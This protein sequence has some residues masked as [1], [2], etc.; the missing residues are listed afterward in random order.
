MIKPVIGSSRPFLLLLVSS[1]ALAAC[2]DDEAMDYCKNHYRFHPEHKA[3][4][5]TLKVELA[6]DGRLHSE[7]M[8]PFALFGENGAAARDR[9]ETIGRKLQAEGQFYSLQSERPCGPFTVTQDFTGGALRLASTAQCGADNKVEQVDVA[10]FDTLP[11]LDEIEVLVTTP[12]TAKR[13]AISR[14]CD[15]ALFRLDE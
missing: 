3:G 15:H 9:L 13:F 12:A 8:I 11:E 4:L 14:Q 6:A 7:L 1:V 10:L 5:S 2:T